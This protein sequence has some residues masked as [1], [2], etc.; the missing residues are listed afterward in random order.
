MRTPVEVGIVGTGARLARLVR[1]FEEVSCARLRWVCDPVAEMRPG[2]VPHRRD[3]VRATIR[4]DDLLLDEELDAIVVA[5]PLPTHY[6]LAWAALN[7]DKH[8]LLDAPA[9][10]T[11]E[12]SDTLVETAMHRA[13][14][15]AVVQPLLHYPGIQKLKELIELGRLGELYYLRVNRCIAA[16]DT[17]AG[18]V[19]P[20]C[21]EPLAVIP[22]LLDDEPV[23]LAARAESYAEPDAVELVVCH[24][25][26]ATGITVVLQASVLEPRASSRLAVVGSRR[27]AVFDE[28]QPHRELTV[29]DRPSGARGRPGRVGE[30]VRPQLGEGDPLVLALEHFV[31][32]VRDTGPVTAAPGDGTA[33]VHLIEALQQSIERGSAAVPIRG[34]IP[35]AAPVI[36]LPVR[37]P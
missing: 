20:L 31:D 1:A 18:G 15:L 34:R 9:T 14:R 30:I 24:L 7:A 17:A 6:E 13:R 35:A 8:V 32:R 21:A 22:Y 5:T 27:M 33:A 23:E 12:Q 36:R 16:A 10:E 4:V 2:P 25:R 19:W 26:F 28:L 37:R 11:S 29:Y 3:R